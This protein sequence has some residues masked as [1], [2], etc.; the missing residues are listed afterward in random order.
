MPDSAVAR[1]GLP[2]VLIVSP[3]YGGHSGGVAVFTED[4]AGSLVRAGVRVGALVVT[5]DSFVPRRGVGIHGEPVV[6]ASP[7]L[8]S[9]VP[10]RARSLAGYWARRWLTA[11]G[12]LWLVARVRPTVAHFHYVSNEEYPWMVALARR[13]GLRVVATC[14]GSDLSE[15]ALRPPADVVVRD[16][17]HAAD[18]VTVVSGELAEIHDRLY[19]ELHD[20]MT[21]IP[22]GAT[23]TVWDAT[24]RAPP[25]AERDVD[26][27][28]IGTFYPFKGVDLFVDTLVR[29][30]PRRPG[31]RAVIIGDGPL[32]PEVERKLAEAGLTDRVTLLGFVPRDEVPGYLRRARMLVVSS[33]FEGQPLV[34]IESLVSGTPVVAFDVGGLRE[35]VDDGATGVIVPYLDVGALA[36]AIV[37]LHGDDERR[38]AMT[39]AARARSD[40]RFDPA[41]LTRRY[42][43]VYRGEPAVAAAV[44]TGILEAEVSSARR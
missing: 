1:P 38:A 25:D 4:L 17:V 37:A 26:L 27:L 2:A 32:R 16:V 5:G 28:F 33:R 44:P 18:A 19:P 40:A 34:V 8:R 29:A 24:R 41:V 20:R 12:F 30:L 39:A 11:A 42:L 14:H 22:N 23:L 10:A 35:L 43:A 15:E 31:A 21:C 36:D 6:R 13:L 3:W 7:S 9:T